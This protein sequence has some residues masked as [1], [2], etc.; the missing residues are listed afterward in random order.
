MHVSRC[1]F[2]CQQLSVLQT[3]VLWNITAI[4]S[5]RLQLTKTLAVVDAFGC[6]SFWIQ[7]VLVLIWEFKS[8]ISAFS[9][10]VNER[11]YGIWIW[12]SNLD[13]SLIVENN[14]IVQILE[15]QTLNT[16]LQPLS[17]H[18]CYVFSLFCPAGM[19]DV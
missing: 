7:F 12:I 19:E 5:L 6:S 10:T 11:S 14:V 18:A 16:Y 13:P 3:C 1:I 2:E 15:R 8:N 9:H 4:H 17:G